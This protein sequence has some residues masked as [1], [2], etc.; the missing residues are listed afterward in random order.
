MV[1]VLAGL[2]RTFSTQ[3]R[4]DARL[5]MTNSKGTNV[6]GMTKFLMTNR[7]RGGGSVF[8]RFM[9]VLMC[10]PAAGGWKRHAGRAGADTCGL[11]GGFLA[12]WDRC[13]GPERQKTSLAGGRSQMVRLPSSIRH[14]CR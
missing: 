8:V 5:E 2:E 11:E 4:K 13:F 9:M 12:L 14:C 6:K 1:G 10:W 3:R 7:E